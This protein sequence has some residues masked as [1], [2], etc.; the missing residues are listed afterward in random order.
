MTYKPAYL[1]LPLVVIF[2]CCNNEWSLQQS[3]NGHVYISGTISS[4]SRSNNHNFG[5]YA[6]A[7]DS[8]F[9]NFTLKNKEKLFLPFVLENK[10]AEIY[11]HISENDSAGMTIVL[12]SDIN[13]ISVI[14]KS[15][16][17]I[18]T[19]FASLVIDGT[20]KS[21]VRDHTSFTAADSK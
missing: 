1:L 18:S 7:V 17:T 3:I 9:V 11:T 16:D 15:G 14:N 5:I 2:L 13:M 8:S 12:N 6:V 20:D 10:T 4:I 19:H 21:F